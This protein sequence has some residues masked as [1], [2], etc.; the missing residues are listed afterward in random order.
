METVMDERS[1]AQ[2]FAPYK[3]GRPILTGSGKKDEFDAKAVDCPFVFYHN[4][5]YYMMYVGFDGRGYQTGLALSDD[6]LHWTKLGVILSR[7]ENV[8]WD[9][10]GAAGVSLLRGSND[11]DGLPKLKKVNGRYWMV[12]HSYPEEG[13]EAGAARIGL[14]WCD[15]E[16]LLCWH[17]LP[18]PVM[19]W[20]NGKNWE[21]GG[22]YK[23][24][25]MEREGCYYLFY[26]AKNV[27]EGSW[28]E[29]VGVAFSRDM[30]SWTRYAGNPVLSV[31]DGA[32]DSAFCSDPFVV[33]DGNRWLMFYYGFDR[34]HAQNGIAVSNDLLHWEKYPEPILRSGAA[35]EDLDFFHAHKPSVLRVNG[36]MY[37]FYCAVRRF[38]QGD[39][40]ENLWNEFRCIT[41][42]ASK[43]FRETD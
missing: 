12:Y 19:T 39:A 36:T 29:Q 23:G 35:Q 6:L 5:K 38:R 24:F 18:E 8:G 4:D 34:R 42:A 20:E 16:S 22:L 40:A 43:P 41:V 15:D 25:L 1:I 33:R 13:Y 26:N 17:R 11:L 28:I 10:V 7:V 3:L 37:H 21:K 9:C 30:I 14:A 2:Y 32:W 27:M 31:A